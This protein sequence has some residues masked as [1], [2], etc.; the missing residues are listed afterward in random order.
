MLRIAFPSIDT[1]FACIPPS[2]FFLFS[3]K[4]LLDSEGVDLVFVP[5][6]Q[7]MYPKG[8]ASV[9]DPGPAFSSG[10]GE[11]GARP[12]HFRGVAT[13]IPSSC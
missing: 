5:S 10:P 9:V 7:E 1:V 2:S 12:T 8:F 3:I 4:E 6:P 13:V 11:A